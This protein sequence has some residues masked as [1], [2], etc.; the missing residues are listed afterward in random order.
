MK[1]FTQ[2][3]LVLSI[4]FLLPNASPIL[5][6]KTKPKA[7][8]Y[9]E[10]IYKGVKWRLVGP[11]RGGRSGTAVGVP[12]Q[13]KLYYMGTAGGGVWRTQDGGNSWSCISDGYFGGSIGAVAVSE[14][15]PNVIYVGEG[16]QT[17]RGNVSSGWGM[18]RSTDAGK[19]WK[20]IGL[21][22][23]E[24]IGRIRIH[25]TNPDLVYVAAMGNLWKP[26]EERGVYRS[27]DGGKTW[28]KI[29]Y[30]SDKAGAVD[31]ILDPNNP[32]IIYA[33]TWQIK[34]NGYRMDSGGPG[35]HLWKS[36][37]LGDT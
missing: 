31:L 19:S 22:K 16:E 11:F 26:N 25:P 5:A 21:E 37:D 17:V 23:S 3:L 9:Q 2:C 20:H 12:G 18:W 33:S 35:S 10:D 36:T 6:Q 27:K 7:E 30:E 1:L 34:R 24:H 29:L 14:S 4:F 32:R 13:P 15:D 28:E 8:T